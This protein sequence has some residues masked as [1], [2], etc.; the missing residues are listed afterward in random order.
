[1]QRYI[2]E[3][4]C[5]LA[6]TPPL[7][8]FGLSMCGPVLLRFGTRQDIPVTPALNLTPEVVTTY[9]QPETSPQPAATKVAAAASR[10]L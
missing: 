1:M 10:K 6:G 3:E 4:E 8:P 2:F 7:V 9:R 5:G